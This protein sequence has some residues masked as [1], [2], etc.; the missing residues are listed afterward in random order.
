VE[1]RCQTCRAKLPSRAAWCGQCFAPV[2]PPRASIA[3]PLTERRGTSGY[4]ATSPVALLEAPPAAPP[5]AV[6]V[7]GR[8]PGGPDPARSRIGWTTVLV[9][10]AILLGAL[11]LEVVMP[12]LD[13]RN[14]LESD[15]AMR[16]GIVLTVLLYALVGSA[17]LVYLHRTGHRLRWRCG[18]PWRGVLLGVACG[19]AAVG[20][21]LIL[22]SAITGHV[23]TDPRITQLVSDGSVS[24]ILAAVLITVVAAPLVEETLFRGVFAES[25]RPRGTAAAIAASA[26]AFAAWHLNPTALRYYALMGVLFGLLYWRRGLFASIAAHATFN[27]VLTAIAIAGVLGPAHS[28]SVDGLTL[29]APAGWSEVSSPQVGLELTGPSGAALGIA[30]EPDGNAQ[31]SPGDILARLEQSRGSNPILESADLAGAEQLDLPAGVALDVT[32]S[33]GGHPLQIVYLPEPGTMYVITVATEGNVRAE[34]DAPDILRS[35]RIA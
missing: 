11:L 7:P 27:G 21:L 10:G 8:P 18:P 33:L 1:D 25:L 4:P 13:S 34:A 14:R 23:T 20:L 30:V 6:P 32:S 26:F 5:R 31:P 19:G 15:A 2:G 22:T 35:V 16:Y 28:Y 24:R 3:A 17:V 29:Q 9:V 12:L